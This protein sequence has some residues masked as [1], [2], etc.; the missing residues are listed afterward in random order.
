MNHDQAKEISET[1]LP[2]D[3][4]YTLEA[5][6][7]GNPDAFSQLTE[8]YRL[9][10]RAHCYRVLGSL[11]DAEDLVQETFLRAW[12]RL[13][14][15]EGRASFRAWLYKIATNACL[16][17][18]EHLPRRTLPLEEE[19]A[20]GRVAAGQAL[21]SE[22]AWIEPIP[23]TWVAASSTGPEARYD[24][25]ESVS[26][27]FLVALQILPPRQR[28]ALVLADV[29]DWGIAEIADVLG[30][31]SSASTSLLHRARETMK[32]RNQAGKLYLSR[33]RFP[34]DQTRQILDRYA[35]AWESAD[36]NGI[37]SML[38]DDAIFPMPPMLAGALRKPAMIKLYQEGIFA[39]DANGRWK[40]VPIHA[41]G[42]PG[43]AFYRLD[44]ATRQY[45]AYCLQVLMIE[46]ELVTNVTTFGFPALFPYFGLPASL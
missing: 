22:P 13:E 21:D 40:L 20:G 42:L 25:Y 15:F 36:L 11:E 9:E 8:P 17:A 4:A 6:K 26:L 29:M 16:D 18:L 41:N 5:A 3:P 7:G 10:L 14:T 24:A 1:L 23:D 43:F 33:I 32:Q 19:D 39:G 31:S 38:A 35:R 44:E 46:N 45:G 12:R 37:I 34:D 28:T 30:I 27:A 2:E